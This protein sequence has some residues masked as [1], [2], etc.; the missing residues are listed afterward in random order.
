MAV[1]FGAHSKEW[2][3]LM[4][5]GWAPLFVSLIARRFSEPEYSAVAMPL[6]LAI[7]QGIACLLFAWRLFRKPGSNTVEGAEQTP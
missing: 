7:F 4:Y 5:F 2:K 3:P 1:C 6:I